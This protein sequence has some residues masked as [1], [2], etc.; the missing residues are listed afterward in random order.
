MYS[1]TI[2]L[3]NAALSVRQYSPADEVEQLFI[4]VM[5]LSTCREKIL[6]KLVVPMKA[7]NLLKA[8]MIDLSMQDCDRQLLQ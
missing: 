8:G 6:F 7:V 5:N 1:Q 2:A 4:D 3:E